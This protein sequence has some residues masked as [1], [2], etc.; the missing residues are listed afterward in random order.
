MQVLP[1]DKF[2]HRMFVA[3]RVKKIVRMRQIGMRK[4]SEKLRFALKLRV[5]LFEPLRQRAIASMIS[6]SRKIMTRTLSLFGCA[7]YFWA[8]RIRSQKTR[9]LPLQ[10]ENIVCGGSLMTLL[11]RFLI[12]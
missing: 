7:I 4:R 6:Q 10:V 1:R 12:A 5:C 3:V 9:N 11:P 2:H 8:N